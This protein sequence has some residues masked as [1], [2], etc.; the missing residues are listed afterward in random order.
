MNQ[1]PLEIYFAG[2]LFDAKDLGGNL[3]LAD[4]I[5]KVSQGKY[6]VLLPQDG[7]CEVINRTSRNIRDAD[8]HLLYSCD[9]IIANLD[10]P[11]PDS[12]TVVEYCFAKMLDIPA[13]LLRTDFRNSGD[14]TLPD[15]EPW[16]LMCSHYPRTEVRHI[17]AMERY[18]RFR[19]GTKSEFL[20]DFYNSIAAD[21]CA[22]L[23]KVTKEKSWLSADELSRA[24]TMAQKSIG[25]EI[26]SAAEAGLI[27]KKK[28][29]SGLYQA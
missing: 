6:K 1:R 7:E 23:D 18:H 15:S 22:A 21:V 28:S 14:A 29:E 16:N 4:A 3:L 26:F 8:F 5:E 19:N 17:N 20:K 10:G 27:V 13:V 25:A 9:I 12:G 11:D 24:L 2:D